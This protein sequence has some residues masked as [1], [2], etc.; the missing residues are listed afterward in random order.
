MTSSR[1]RV[2]RGSALLLVLL[3]GV[4]TL[5]W[6]VDHPPG[7][8]LSLRAPEEAIAVYRVRSI[9]VAASIGAALAVSGVLLQALLRNPL[10]SPFILGISSGA[11]LGVMTAMF[12]ATLATGAAARDSLTYSIGALAGAIGVMLIVYLLGRRRGVLDPLSLVL[13]GVVIAAM[14]GAGMMILEL[15]VPDGRR[16]DLLIWMMGRVPQEATTR[17]ILFLAVIAAFGVVFGCMLGKAMDVATFGDDEARS[18]GLDLAPIRSA[19]F[20]VAAGLAAATVAV[21]GPIAFVGLIAP[22]AAR[23]LIG[24]RHTALVPAAA[25]AGATLVVAAD[26]AS[27]AI[28]FGHGRVPVGVFTA[29]IGG[30]AF[31]WLLRTGRG[32]A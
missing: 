31:I 21:A 23:L 22:H 1:T 9:A 13:V 11:G 3:I 6:F 8:S 16:G 17:A 32:Q 25:I 2:L 7:G 14:C 10:A 28:D 30:P 29:L 27:A 19:M 26:A 15:L 5:R 4:G 18:I 12:L 24:P 20:V